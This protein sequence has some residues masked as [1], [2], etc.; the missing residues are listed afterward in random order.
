M[1]GIAEVAKAMSRRASD[2]KQKILFVSSGGF[3]AL[4][5][6]DLRKIIE[7]VRARGWKIEVVADSDIETF[8]HLID[9]M[10]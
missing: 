8:G 2:V 9:R 5:P 3:R 10:R 4:E 6:K 1:R 7:D